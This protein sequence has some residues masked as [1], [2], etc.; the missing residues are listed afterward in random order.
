[1]RARKAGDLWFCGRAAPERTNWV[2]S[3]YVR[4]MLQMS[5]IAY[6]VFW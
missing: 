5:T 4:S 2:L 6:A 3:C 1:M